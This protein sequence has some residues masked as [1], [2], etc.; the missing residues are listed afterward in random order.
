[1]TLLEEKT[2]HDLVSEWF[3]RQDVNPPQFQEI[4]LLALAKTAL[5]SILTEFER[6]DVE[7]LTLF[8]FGDQLN[9]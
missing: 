9:H 1:M 7:R 2:M 5:N 4:H 3:V 8:G 6:A